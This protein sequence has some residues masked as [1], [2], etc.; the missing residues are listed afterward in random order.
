[1]WPGSPPLPLRSGPKRQT[2]LA[3][4]P[5]C[6]TAALPV[7]LLGVASAFLP[8]RAVEGLFDAK[9]ANPGRFGASRA[10][11]ASA[12][13][14][15]SGMHGGDQGTSSRDAVCARLRR[16]YAPLPPQ[17]Q[18]RACQDG[19][20]EAEELVAEATMVRLNSVW[21][22]RYAVPYSKGCFQFRQTLAQ[23]T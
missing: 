10:R 3:V 21:M 7:T 17:Q 9:A 23:D 14:E 2:R 19:E 13:P 1:M 12:S 20:E 18:L 22:E 5:L 4:T 11:V 8:V 15:A 6:G 16:Q